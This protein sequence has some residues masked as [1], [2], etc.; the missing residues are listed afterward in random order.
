[1]VQR[2]ARSL[3]SLSTIVAQAN[4]I[5]VQASPSGEIAWHGA[6]TAAFQAGL[7][8]GVRP[9]TA[10]HTLPTL[11][12]AA[13]TIDRARSSLP[14]EDLGAALETWRTLVDGRSTLV[15][16]FEWEGRQFMVLRSQ[17]SGECVGA[18][19]TARE[20]QVVAY[21]ARG[22]AL[23]YIAYELGLTAS[24]ISSCAAS[25]RAKLGFRS[26][27]EMIAAFSQPAQPEQKPQAELSAPPGLRRSRL[28][29]GGAQLV[30][31]SFLRC[32]PEIPTCLSEAERC[33]L[34][35][36]LSGEPVS[37]IA[38][39]RGTS[40]HTVCNQVASIYKKL[41]VGSRAELVSKLR[42]VPA[43]Q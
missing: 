11:E 34:R 32:D 30:V 16:S 27:V 40:L 35:F 23:K 37:K 24:T 15:L 4:Q 20:R 2:L 31:L 5:P 41:R 6:H 14:L 18:A 10:R 7:P 12:E 33:V 28:V 3:Q 43:R 25:A 13:V 1:M 42:R 9:A 19:L 39:R 38:E 36:L 8:S 26:D 29:Y 21:R 17:T 22:Y